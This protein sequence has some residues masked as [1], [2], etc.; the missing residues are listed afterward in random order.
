MNL[1]KQKIFEILMTAFLSAG[2]AFLQNLLAQIGHNQD[3]QNDAVVAGGI[4]AT[5]KYLHTFV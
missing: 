3:L 4:G 5:L 1:N 2:I